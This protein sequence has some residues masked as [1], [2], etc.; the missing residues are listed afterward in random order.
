[1]EEVIAAADVPRAAAYR[2]WTSRERF[3]SDVL[4]QLALGQTLP[5]TLRPDEIDIVVDEVAASTSPQDDARTVLCSLTALAIEREFD[6]LTDS[7]AWRAFLA[8]EAAVASLPDPGRRTTLVRRFIEA[9]AANAARIAE[10]YRAVGAALELRPNSEQA[11]LDAAHAAR[12]LTRGL[13]GEAIREGV[14]PAERAALR[15]RLSTSTSAIFGQTFQPDGD[16]TA[17]VDWQQSVL[18]VFRRSRST[19]RDLRNTT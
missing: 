2:L 13:I 10:I 16:G 14:S 5:S 15:R 19:E 18:A 17:P 12:I 4:E 7:D 8:L 9:E 1:M 11:L 3:T 6:L